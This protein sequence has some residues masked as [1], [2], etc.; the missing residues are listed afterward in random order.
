MTRE[1]AFGFF[2]T[3]LRNVQNSW[4]A[5]NEQTKVVAATFW[6]NLLS[7]GRYQ[8]DYGPFKHRPGYKGLCADIA[9]SLEHCGGVLK[10]VWASNTTGSL[11]TPKGSSWEPSKTLEMRIKHFDPD[12]GL[13]IAEVVK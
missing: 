11:K 7:G 2:A 4:S 3:K 13:F 10:V 5:R 8:I 9:Y 6:R 12:G 1:Q